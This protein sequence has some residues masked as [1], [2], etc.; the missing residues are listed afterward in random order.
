[1]HMQISVV[2]QENQVLATSRPCGYGVALEYK[3]SYQ[4]GDTVLLTIEEVGLY[5]LQIDECL[6]TCIV[7]LEQEARFQIPTEAEKRTCYPKL[8][9]TGDCHL[10]TLTP[11]TPTERRNLALNVYDHHQAKGIHPHA[12]ANVETRGEMVFAARNAI[13]GVFA[14]HS[15]GDYPYASW[16]INRDPKAEMRIEFGRSVIADEIR[17]TLRADWPHD[18]WWTEAV[19]T[20]SNGKRYVLPLTKSPLPQVFPIEPTSMTSL[21]LGELKKADDPS[22]F[23]AL[24]Q[25]EVWGTEA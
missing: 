25:I 14:N 13:D 7:H 11:F 4:A 2:N 15:H 23:P 24:T 6:G 3:Q 17:L 21:T 5:E 19:V 1:M 10:M 22:P 18:S 16:G 12:S 20:D 8:A 9:F